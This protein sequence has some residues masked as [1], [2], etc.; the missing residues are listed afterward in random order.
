MHSR[1]TG[2]GRRIP[3]SRHV[4]T[5]HSDNPRS[6]KESDTAVDLEWV[7]RGGLGGEEGR[8]SGSGLLLGLGFVVENRRKAGC[9][10]AGVSGSISFFWFFRIFLR[11][12]GNEKNH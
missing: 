12:T 5:A 2:V 8:L 3:S 1:W 11:K 9:S 4:A 6:E 7:L 10:G